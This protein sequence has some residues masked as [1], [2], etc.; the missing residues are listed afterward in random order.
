[1]SDVL[2]LTLL[3]ADDVHCS[4]LPLAHIYERG[5]LTAFTVAGARI[6]FYR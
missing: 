5:S 2:D 6:G 3:L 1:M 4:Y